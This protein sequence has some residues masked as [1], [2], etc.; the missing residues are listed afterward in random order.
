MPKD[1]WARL[2]PLSFGPCNKIFQRNPSVAVAA[3]D[4]N[5]TFHRSYS[6][7]R[8]LFQIIKEL[9]KVFFLALHFICFITHRLENIIKRSNFLIPTK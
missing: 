7:M 1:V 4:C 9:V 6:E 2:A 3:T 8:D 5:L